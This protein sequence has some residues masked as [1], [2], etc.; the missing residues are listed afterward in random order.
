MAATS[1]EEATFLNRY[2]RQIGTYGIEAMMR[3]T[4]MKVLI[5][6]MKG[7]GVEIAKNLVLAG[8]KGVTIHDPMPTEMKDLG[9]NFFL[10]M[11][12]IGKPRAST[13][14][15]RLQE[16]NEAVIVKASGEP[17]ITEA[18]IEAHHVVV[19]THGLRKDQLVRWNGHCR[20]KNIS[21]INVFS[22]GL[23]CSVFV[24][25]GEKFIIRDA[26]GEQPL[27]RIVESISSEEYGLVK[28][29]VPDG[30]T[31]GSIPDGSAVKLT[32]VEGMIS[33]LNL[34]RNPSP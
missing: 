7:P 31:P 3:L 30:Q 8:I 21:F 9:A 15:P 17:H 26:D 29:I 16:L 14:E 27:I 22:G 2:S 12:D 4:T 34:N 19:V 6:G 10:N 33:N 5:I 20:A 28:F 1:E 11:A 32:E 18:L 13:I 23:A 25:H 24:D